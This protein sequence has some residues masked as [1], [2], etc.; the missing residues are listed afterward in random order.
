[1]KT[2]H[3]WTTLTPDTA[4]VSLNFSILPAV[5]GKRRDTLVISISQA[6][7]QELGWSRGTGLEMRASN[8][9]LTYQ[10]SPSKNPAGNQSRALQEHQGRFQWR[11][12]CTG[13]VAKHWNFEFT[14]ARPLEVKA[15][16]S[17][18]LTFGFSEENTTHE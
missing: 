4:V 9:G 13:E 7:A 14:S 5:H 2:T 10:L 16:E 15:I 17:G 3:T 12:P 18:T 8:D 11:I 6:L 1:M